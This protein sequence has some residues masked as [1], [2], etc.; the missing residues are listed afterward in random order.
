MAFT[1]EAPSCPP[2][3]RMKNQQS[4]KLTMAQATLGCVQ[5]ENNA[6][7]WAGIVG[8]ADS[9]ELLEEKVAAILARSQTQSART[10]FS[11]MKKELKGKMLDAAVVVCSGL[12]ALASAT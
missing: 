3:N 5:H 4:N 9:V 10:G 2:G 7:L 6:P 12:K 11:A 1:S 8:I